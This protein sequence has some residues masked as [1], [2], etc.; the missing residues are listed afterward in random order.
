MLRQKTRFA[1]LHALAAIPFLLS[2]IVR[3]DVAAD[4]VRLTG[5]RPVRLVWRRGETVMVFD[6]RR[7]KERELAKGLD[8]VDSRPSITADARRVAYTGRDAKVYVVNWD[9]S[10][11]RKL[12]D[13]AHLGCTWRDPATGRGFAFIQKYPSRLSG[14]DFVKRNGE[15]PIY[16]I[17]IDNPEKQ[18]LVWNKSAAC[19][20]WLSIT[21]DG[22]TIGGAFPWPDCG[23][24]T[25]PNGQFVK[26]GGGCYSAISPD[27]RRF[28]IF[29]GPHRN[30]FHYDVA[31]RKQ[32]GVIHLA[33]GE[34]IG[35]NEVYSPR[36]SNDG[37]F[38]T[39]TGPLRDKT[40]KSQLY[41]GKLNR[42]RTEVV[43]WVKVTNSGVEEFAGH[44]W[45][46][47]S[48]SAQI[49]NRPARPSITP[50]SQ[51]PPNRDGLVFLWEDRSKQNEVAEATGEPSIV[52]RVEPRSLARYGRHY[53]MA[54]GGG[55]FLANQNEALL[56]ACQKSNQLTVEAIVTAGNLQQSGPARIVTLSSSASSRNFTL[57]QS[58]DRLIFRLRTS[59]SD[60][61]GTKPEVEL[62]AI[63]ANRPNHVIVTYKPGQLICYLDGRQVLSTSA[64]SGDFSNWASQHLLF[65]DEYDGARDWEGTLEGIGIY[66]RIM[67]PQEAADAYAVVARKIH[68]R[69]PVEQVVVQAKLLETSTVPAPQTIAPCRRC[70]VFNVYQVDKVESGKL[71]EQKIVAAHWAILDS[72]VLPTAVRTVGKMYRMTLERLDDHPELNGERQ[73]VDV[74]EL[75]LPT[76]L[77][78]KS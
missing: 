20:D 6:T 67:E 14:K 5:G 46:E 39:I 78:V 69:K 59:R 53:A 23:T 56:A 16:R 10:G 65:G 15:F 26:Y 27:G 75:D 74:E 19:V 7:G 72:K 60:G 17:S 2:G 11:R 70:L 62:C 12:A 40:I 36:F 54:L 73:A 58:R 38:V 35:S 47:G 32:I 57:G 37:R 21:D 71:M 45:I 42:E 51:W 52:C 34:G 29:D 18:D 28:V 30:W 41:L 68:D 24:I 8:K 63:K 64:L 4:I 66:N 31:S 43:A 77:D 25:F 3:A 76:Y 33:A 50:A 9:G 48:N 44:A 1:G 55:A 13:N 49:A 22:T 61:N